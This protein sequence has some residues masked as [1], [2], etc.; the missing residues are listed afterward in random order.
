MRENDDTLRRGLYH[1]EY[2]GVKKKRCR[3]VKRAASSIFIE[4]YKKKIYEKR[5]SLEA[6]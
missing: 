1:L 4:E 5:A 3:P 6:L 2:I